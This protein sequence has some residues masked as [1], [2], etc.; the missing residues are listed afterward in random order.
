MADYQEIYVRCQQDFIE[1]L[2]AEFAALGFDTFQENEDGF[3]TFVEGEFDSTMLNQLTEQYGTL[4]SFSYLTKDVEKQNWNEEWEKH[5]EPIVVEEECIVKAPFHINA[6]SYPIELLITPKMSFGTGH[7]ETT[8]LMLA[9]MLTMDFG[10][11][12]VM[13]A[14]TGTGVLAI[15]AKKQGAIRVFAFD[16]DEWCIENAM[17]NA[18]ANQVAVEVIKASIEG[19]DLE[20]LYDVLVAN[21]NKNVLMAQMA[22]YSRALKQG[23]DL[24]LSGFY[25]EDEEDIR[26]LAHQ[27][28][29]IFE[30]QRERNNWVMLRFKKVGE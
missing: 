9:E 3:T 25:K 4:A 30:R 26:E 29:F 13:D 17:E 12:H 28:G 14:G 2:I 1:I 16:V 8:Y 6:P 15:L 22:Y 7:H 21:I 27:E 24:L 20:P 19:I 18:E 11:K 23:G 10:G 5:Y